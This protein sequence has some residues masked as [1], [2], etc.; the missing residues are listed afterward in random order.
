MRR[1]ALPFVAAGC[2]N[3]TASLNFSFTG[4]LPVPVTLNAR[5]PTLL[6]SFLT[7]A[8]ITEMIKASKSKIKKYTIRY[9]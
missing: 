3:R 1:Y 6:Y 2:E 4:Q 7:K 9:L 5:N 8:T